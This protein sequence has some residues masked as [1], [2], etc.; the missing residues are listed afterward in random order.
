MTPKRRIYI[1]APVD[2]NLDQDQLALK[3][4]MLHA[5]ENEG[6]EP[7]EFLSSG[8]PKT[9]AWGFEAANQVMSRCQGAAIL[10]FARWRCTPSNREDT[11]LDLPSEYSHFEGAL[12]FS[13]KLPLLVITDR[14]IRT[15]GITLLS[16]GPVIF[17]PDGK[18]PEWVNDKYF[19]TGQFNE[20]C[21]Q[22]KS[23]PHVF[24]GYCS[25]ARNTAI[26]IARFMEHDLDLIVREYSMD[27]QAG[28]TIL[29][30]IE[31]ACR[32]STCGVFLFTKDDQLTGD[33]VHAAPRDNVIFEAG[34]F[35][36]AKGKE[37]VLVI[38]EEGANMP[39]DIGGNI[40]IPL[41][42]RNDISGIHTQLRRF[43]ENRL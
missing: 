23:R 22:V 25:S 33:D 37:Q 40:Y 1:S 35:M 38:R 4:A 10:A 24:L 14:K 19:L 3:M 6:F 12:A 13:H 32:E 27:F 5:I 43:L 42:D 29:E 2:G 39:A 26:D 7:Q 28:G 9:L 34:Y 18:G 15:S 11:L 41:K 31:D 17:W 30:Q 21:N 16:E 20:W 36:H 8:I